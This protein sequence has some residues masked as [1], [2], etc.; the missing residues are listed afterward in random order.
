MIGTNDPSK[1][2]NQLLYLQNLPLPGVYDLSDGT[3]VKCIAGGGTVIQHRGQYSN[4]ENYFAKT[5]D[6]YVE[7]F[8]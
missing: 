1:N 2:S 8:G 5:W 6:E 3:T 4:A 7:G